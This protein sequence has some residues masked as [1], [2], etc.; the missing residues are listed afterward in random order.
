M[1]AI[2]LLY[3]VR[4]RNPY[5]GICSSQ[6]ARSYDI[7]LDIEYSFRVLFA[8]EDQITKICSFFEFYD[9]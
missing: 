6:Y 8:R 5:L 1:H 9:N 7:E 3:S 2:F 4:H